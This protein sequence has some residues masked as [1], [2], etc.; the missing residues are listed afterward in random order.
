MQIEF[1]MEIKFYN[2]IDDFKIKFVVIIAKHNGKFVLCKHKNR[3]TFEIPGGHRENYENVFDAAKRELFEETGA[4]L[5][6][7]RKICP[8]SVDG[9][10]GIISTNEE[11]FGMLYYAE[12][13]EFNKISSEIEKIEF[14]EAF[15]NE[16]LTYPIIH[17]ILYKKYL[18]NN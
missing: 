14:F 10:D 6:E 8:Y 4:S 17:S 3:R 15:P 1:I 13:F 12:I 2:E 7:I 11:S 5:F 9:N 18:E 16:N